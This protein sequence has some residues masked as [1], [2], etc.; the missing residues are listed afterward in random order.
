[1]ADYNRALEIDPNGAKGYVGRG[2]AERAKGDLD[3]AMAEYNHAI[4]VDPKYAVAY[5][6]RGNTHYV[7]Q[8]WTDAL[9]DFR[10]AC[11]LLR[12]RRNEDYVRLSIWLVRARVGETE[13]AN[14]ELTAYLGKRGNAAPGDWIPNVAG[15]LVGNVS[16]AD[17]FAAAK[18]PD[19][20][21]ERGQLCEAW[22]YAGMKKLV[23]GDK[24]VAEDY[25]K[26]CIA[27][28]ETTFTEYEYAEAEL[29]KLEH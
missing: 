1:M 2:D 20:N 8:E 23:S 4:E 17:L 29:K 5:V 28:Q 15:H 14:K 6:A 9:V 13:A 7:K 27:T 16:E 18:S 24:G 22:F 10:S 25:L 12:N 3:P 11:E 26:K 19:S 21:K